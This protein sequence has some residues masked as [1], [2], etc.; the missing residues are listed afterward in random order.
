VDWRLT[1][2][3][4]RDCDIVFHCFD[5]EGSSH[6]DRVGIGSWGRGVETT[7][8]RALQ[9]GNVGGSTT[10]LWGLGDGGDGENDGVGDGLGL[11]TV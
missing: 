3:P 7:P 8:T 9:E 2:M 10:K 4:D 6:L 1:G 5:P 11:F